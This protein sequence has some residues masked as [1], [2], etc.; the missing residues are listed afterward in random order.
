MQQFHSRLSLAIKPATMKKIVL[1]ATLLP[2]LI[3]IFT[4]CRKVDIP[5]RTDLR[6]PL[7]L[8]TKD[9]TGD[10]FILA[11]DPERF[12]GKFVVDLYYGPAV[13]PRKADIVVI[14]NDNRANVKT[15]Q[16]DVTSFPAHIEITDEDLMTLFD[17]TIKFGD[18]FEIGADV[19][20]FNGQKFEAFPVNGIPYGADTAALAGHRF[21]I[22]Y[23]ATCLF[24][25]SSFSG[26]YTVVRNEIVGGDWGNIGVGDLV[27]VSPGGGENEILVYTFPTLDAYL[28]SRS[29]TLCQVDPATLDVIV[30]RQLT[31]TAM[32]SLPYIWMETGTAPGKVNPCGDSITLNMTLS[33]VYYTYL[34]PGVPF[35]T[36]TS[37]GI[38][39]LMK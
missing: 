37:T 16:A 20:I 1:F 28:Y 21:S 32:F 5:V 18:K 27:L 33:A 34:D 2:V 39:E 6:F 17:S 19:T 38:L 23:I 13:K 31:G 8:I 30:P 25:K 7:P 24:E 15:I 29:P 22:V 10:D 35:Y 3:T 26:W 12:V 36:Y 9:T 14:R 4:A 11:R